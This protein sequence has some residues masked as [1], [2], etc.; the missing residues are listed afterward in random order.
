MDLAGVA[1]ELDTKATLAVKSVAEFKDLLYQDILM[2]KEDA[3]ERL[4]KRWICCW[5]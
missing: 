2:R 5:F 1:K 4:S 3:E